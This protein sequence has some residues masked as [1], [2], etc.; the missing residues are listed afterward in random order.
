MAPTQTPRLLVLARHAESERNAA[1]RGSVF[2]PDEAAKDQF[3]GQPDSATGLTENGIVQARALGVR[4][5]AEYGMFDLALDSGYRRTVD[6]LAAVLEAW[7]EV[8]RKQIE[9]R[10]DFLLRERD[11]GHAVN[12]TA[13]EAAGA[14]PW[15][16]DY[17][18]AHG[19]FFARPP[20]G[21]SL[22]DV[23][24]RVRQF[25]ESHRE[26]FAGRRVLIVGHAGS[27]R[28]VRF[29]LEGWSYEEVERRLREE[30]MENCAV[31]AYEDGGERSMPDRFRG[32]PGAV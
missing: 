8:E 5:R 12:M 29:V 28:M 9:R 31:A 1:K 14:F 21:E 7:P 3:Q 11:A 6:T 18:R 4:L 15:L 26:Q 19:P 10:S 30:P 16:Q 32:E 20:G 24:V 2:L 22:A 27:L 13:T 23:A 17:W 25:I